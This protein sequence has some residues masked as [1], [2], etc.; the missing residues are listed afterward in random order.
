M[1]I[2]SRTSLY[3][4]FILISILVCF[5]IYSKAEAEADMEIP[6]GV[7]LDMGSS[8]GKTVHRCIS[9]AVSEFYAVN[10]HYKTRIAL[11]NRDTHGE[12]LHA[13]SAGMPNFISIILEYIEQYICS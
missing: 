8:S 4:N 13:L 12:P 11:H 9:M 3:L 5:Q 10:S 7:I 2:N 1:E 6:V